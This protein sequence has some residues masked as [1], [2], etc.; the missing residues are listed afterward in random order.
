MSDYIALTID[1]S[2][3]P[4]PAP[5]LGAKKILDDLAPGQAMRLISDCSGAR[6]DLLAWC[7]YTG[8]VLVSATDQGGGKVAYLLCKAGRGR[9][10]PAPHVTLDMR[11]V[12]CPVPILEALIRVMLKKLPA[13]WLRYLTVQ[14]DI[15]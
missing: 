12:C 2:G 6:A 10:T 8:H 9:T 4:C 15:T 3:L 14:T 7:Q 5:L 11:G 1:V 13:G